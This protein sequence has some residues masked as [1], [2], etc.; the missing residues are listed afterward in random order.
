M[1]F[2]LH[3]HVQQSTQS[4]QTWHDYMYIYLDMVTQSYIAVVLDM[5]TGDLECLWHD[6]WMYNL[7]LDDVAGTYFENSLY[8][9]GQSEKR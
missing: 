3:L 8:A 2:L 4:V 6:Y 1:S 7:Q 9:F 5:I